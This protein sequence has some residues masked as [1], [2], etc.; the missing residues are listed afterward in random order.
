MIHAN[1]AFIPLGGNRYAVELLNP[2]DAIS[3]GNRALALF[4]P[5]LG[6]IVGSIDFDKIQSIDLI[7]M[8][9][10]EVAGKLQGLVSM[11]FASCGELKSD[12][13]TALM[14]EAIQR[15]YTPQ[16][17]AL[18]DMAVFNRWFREHPGDL[19]P[20]GVMALVH[21]VKDFFPSRLVTA[22]SEF[23]ARTKAAQETGSTS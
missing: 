9:L 10:A 4:G 8:G 19:Y 15:C 23:Q 16:N 17:E 12:A 13:V 6:K 18:S 3:W 7:T 14:T 1:V 20:L 22:A 2:I 11:A 5:S 21:L